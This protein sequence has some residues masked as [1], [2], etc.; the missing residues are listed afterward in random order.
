MVGEEHRALR[1]ARRDVDYPP[2]RGRV[3]LDVLAA[4]E[5]EDVGATDSAA[6][7]GGSSSGRAWPN[8]GRSR[9]ANSARMS[10]GALPA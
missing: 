5:L 2:H 1:M 4:R 9:S 10:E 3:Q 6:G 8:S 7:S